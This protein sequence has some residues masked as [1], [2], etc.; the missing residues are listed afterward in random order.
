[1]A[2]ELD[3]QS[4]ARARAGD[5]AA[6]GQLVRCYERPVY[7]LV[8]RLL[9]GRTRLSV[10][11]LAQEVFVRI[12]R[13]IHRF[14][15]AGPARLSTWILTVATRVCLNALRARRSQEPLLRT[16]HLPETGADPQSAP[17][18]DD[19]NRDLGASPEQI[20]LDRERH[21]RV[22]RAMAALPED[23][24]AVLV[25]R[26]FHDLD[27]PEIAAALDLELG[28]VKSRLSRAR[29]A[30]REALDKPAEPPPTMASVRWTDSRTQRGPV[31]PS[32]RDQQAKEQA[33]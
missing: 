28:T 17:W 31:P 33:S 9:C 24:R 7:A 16:A 15:P 21:D 4:L 20:T 12:L 3:E 18:G 13:G 6:L 14:D 2:D 22:T 27:Y 30:L 32:R 1:V 10:D 19:G 26:A 29:S 25:L 8:G 23:M 11:D 5:P